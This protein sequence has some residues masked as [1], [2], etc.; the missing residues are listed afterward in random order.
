M[1][2]FGGERIS[3]IMNTLKTP[4]DMPIEAK[5]ITNTIESAQKKIEGRNFAIRKS[6]LQYDDV[7][8]RQRELS[9]SREI[10]C[11]T[12]KNSSPLSPA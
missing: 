5:M 11:L 7:M 4:E 1:R 3:T 8:N 12:A 6:V 10:R 2:L 9:I